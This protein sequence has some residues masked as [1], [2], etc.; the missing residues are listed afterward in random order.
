[1]IQPEG[2]S[3]WLY[4]I[5]IP[6]LDGLLKPAD[7][8]DDLEYGRRGGAGAMKAVLYAV[9]SVMLLA[10]VGGMFYFYQHL[11]KGGESLLGEDGALKYTD[12][13]TISPTELLAKPD[14][15]AKALAA[16]PKDEVLVLKAKRGGYYRAETSGGEVGWVPVEDILAV[17]TMGDE[18]VRR[19][20]D[21]LYNP[22]QYTTVSNAAWSMIDEEGNT[23]ASFRFSLQNTSMYDM[24]DL[25]LEAVI[26]DSKGTEVGSREFAI[27]GI[28]PAES[29]T[30]VGTLPPPEEVVKAAKKAGEEPPPGQ[31]QTYATF[32]RDTKLLPEGEEQEARYLRWLDGVEIEVD[33]NFVEATVRIVELRAVPKD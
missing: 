32:E 12:I 20:M 26:K 19:R 18:K 9:F 31:L 4:A 3:D 28:I 23:T 13:I 10:G 2:A 15:G 7:D 14:A 30:M 6:D 5:E 21:P 22:D 25:V 1:L 8:D 29:S 16:L 17:Y 24:T 33:E 11:P 27:E